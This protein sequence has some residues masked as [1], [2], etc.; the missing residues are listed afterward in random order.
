MLP[1]VL[2]DRLR[3][4]LKAI[5]QLELDGLPSRQVMFR[6]RKVVGSGRGGGRRGRGW[7]CLFSYFIFFIFFMLWKS[8][9]AKGTPNVSIIKHC[10]ERRRYASNLNTQSFNI[11]Y[12]IKPKIQSTK[13]LYLMISD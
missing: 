7:M 11:K 12:H 8:N 5:H 3:Q 10:N 6:K 13:I 9:K 4:G 2:A 1:E